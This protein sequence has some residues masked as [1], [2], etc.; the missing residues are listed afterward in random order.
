M[1]NLI[2]IALFAA[3]M[4]A[5]LKPGFTGCQDWL[6]PGEAFML[7]SCTPTPTAPVA[8]VPQ[9]HHIMPPHKRF[10]PAPHHGPSP[11]I[12]VMPGRR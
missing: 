8:P 10:L 3:A 2:V 6:V 11:F 4:A 5:D 9:H 1:K 7:P 12:G